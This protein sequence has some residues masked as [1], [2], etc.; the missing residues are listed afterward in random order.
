MSRGGRK[1]ISDALRRVL[2]SLKIGR[3]RDPLTLMMEIPIPG[4]RY[5]KE[6]AC[7]TKLASLRDKGIFYEIRG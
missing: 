5:N 7:C 2:S 4:K 6:R 1:H 3:S